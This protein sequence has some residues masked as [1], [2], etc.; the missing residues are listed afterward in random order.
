MKSNIHPDYHFVKVVMTDGTEYTTRT[1]WGKEG[2]VLQLDIDAKSHPA[3]TGGTGQ[4]LD[5]AGRVSKFQKKF[6][7]FL[8]A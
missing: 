5:R 6:A 3:W 8:K 2:D 7:G 4:L 1:T